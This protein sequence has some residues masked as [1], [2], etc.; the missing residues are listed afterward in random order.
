VNELSPA[1]RIVQAT[2][3]THR[4]GTGQ[5][6]SGLHTQYRSHGYRAS[7]LVGRGATSENQAILAHA[8]Y[9]STWAR[10]CLTLGRTLAAPGE[11]DSRFAKLA[12]W[13]AE[14]N[15]RRRIR[16]GFEDFQFPATLPAISE[17][18]REGPT[19][20]HLHNLHGGYFDLRALP[21]LC[22]VA[23]LVLT[24]H[25]QWVFTGH[26]AHSF[27]CDRWK[28]GC[29]ECP[30]LTIYPAI[31]RDRTA[32]NFA[33]KEDVF[34]RTRLHLAA[35]CR[36]LMDRAKNSL[37]TPAIAEARV[38]PNGVDTTVFRPGSKA[39][40]R[41]RLDLPPES[42]IVLFA[43]QPTRSQWTNETLLRSTIRYLAEEGQVDCAFLFLGSGRNFREERDG[44]K[45]IHREYERDPSKLAGYYRASDVYFHPARA[46]TFPTAILE[47]LACGTPPV[48]TDVGGIPEQVTSLWASRNASTSPRGSATGILVD[49]EAATGAGKGIDL[50]LRNDSL[51]ARLGETGASIA[52][53]EFSIALQAQRYLDWYREILCHHR[54]AL[55]G[56]VSRPHDRFT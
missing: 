28:I 55:A 22:K 53:S 47:S 3:Q 51:R 56:H 39:K 52:A 19:I 33:L 9:R 18:V 31:P 6:V 30:D 1:F 14:P 35:P 15:R 2:L 10:A 48:A 32:E 41:A 12:S 24:L 11:R 49:G 26:C 42:R 34:S 21:E 16:S 7:V 46:D 38:I 17:L 13:I 29:G 44:V 5:I 36:W 25:D 20:L 23:P 50:L 8:P 45:V 27:D 4:G 43:N 37:L 54:S 40:E